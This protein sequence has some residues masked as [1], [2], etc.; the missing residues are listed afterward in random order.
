MSLLRAAHDLG[1]TV[2]TNGSLLQGE[3]VGAPDIR[4]RVEDVRKAMREGMVG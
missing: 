1:L 4:T 2:I 3:L